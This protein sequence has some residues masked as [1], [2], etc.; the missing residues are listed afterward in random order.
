[1]IG[2]GNVFSDGTYIWND[3]F[4]NYVGRY[5]IP[6]PK[7]FREHLLN[8]FEARMKRHETTISLIRS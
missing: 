6:V 3:I 1:M 2:Y 5:N 4:F 7:E 8:N